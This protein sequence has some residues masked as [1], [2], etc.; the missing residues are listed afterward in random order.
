MPPQ[1][2]YSAD[3]GARDPIRAMRETVD[4]IH[5]LTA[6][7]PPE[8]FEKSYAPGK[9]SARVIL[10]HLAQSELA[11][12][13]R[14]RMALSVP[15]YVAQSF[16]QDA[17][18]ARESRTGGKEAVNALVALSRMNVVLFESL[19]AADRET[20]L[21]HPEFGALTVDWIIHQMA[22]HQIHHLAQLQKIAVQ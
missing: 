18:I 10:T 12:G 1:T 6:A 13:N 3:L 19:S 22:G 8:R 14:I 5:S 21:S 11:F 4:R 17:W 2:P 20:A 7:W 9:W 16:D 15:N